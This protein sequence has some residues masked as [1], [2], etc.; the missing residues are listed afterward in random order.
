M[1]CHWLS[2]RYRL[3]MRVALLAVL[4]APTSLRAQQAVPRP[5]CAGAVI[6]DTANATWKQIDE[7]YFTLADAIR[8]KDVDAIFAL[9]TPDYQVAMPNGEVWSR[10]RSLAYQRDGLARVQE[11]RHVSNTI[12]RLTECD[13]GVMATVLQQWY[14]TQM[15]AGKVRLVE[16]NTLQDELWSRAGGSWLRGNIYEVRPGAAFVDGKRVDITRPY[17]PN[18]PAYDPA[19][20]FKK[21][22]R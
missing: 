7:R 22:D 10:E 14:R 2:R 9:Y 8:S 15:T 17:D 19:A 6:S 3:A 16:T 18:A 12:M 5:R 11:T 20:R 4:A 1:N 13:N 21:P